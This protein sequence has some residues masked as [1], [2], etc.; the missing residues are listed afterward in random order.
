M[1]S[2][3]IIIIVALGTLSFQ[4]QNVKHSRIS[5]AQVTATRLGQML[6][7]DWKSTG[8]DPTYD[9]TSLGLGFANT[10]PPVALNYI[11]TLDNQTFHFQMTQQ[12]AP[13]SSGSNPD[14]V[15][16]VTLQQLSVTVSWRKDYGSGAVSGSDPTLTLTT[17][18]RRDS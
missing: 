11:I 15:A 9:A 6:L 8:G 14:Q 12:L 10:T 13:V 1:V 17:Y 7:E 18:V 16:G 5:E 4:Y 2:A 3:A